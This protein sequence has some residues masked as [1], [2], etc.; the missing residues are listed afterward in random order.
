MDSVWIN[1]RDLI[2]PPT[3]KVTPLGCLSFARFLWISARAAREGGENGPEF[4]S[5]QG[6]RGTVGD[7]QGIL[8]PEAV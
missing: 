1:L 5:L 3:V 2:K 4:R 6:L 8:I 7:L